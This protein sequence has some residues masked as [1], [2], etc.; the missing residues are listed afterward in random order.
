MKTAKDWCNL[1]PEHVAKSCHYDGGR[2]FAVMADALTDANFHGLRNKL[3]SA[4]AD[5]LY[6]EQRKDREDR[7]R[8]QA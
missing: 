6:E 5:W 2:I 4:F 1:T 3:E 7:M 8:G